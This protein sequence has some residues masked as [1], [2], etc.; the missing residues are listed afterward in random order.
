M[1]NEGLAALAADRDANHYAG[2]ILTS[3]ELGR[4]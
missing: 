3:A 2:R 1:G 4:T